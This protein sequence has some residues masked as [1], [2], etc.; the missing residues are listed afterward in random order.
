MR[1]PASKTATTFQKPD[2]HQKQNRASGGVDDC[3]DNSRTEMDTDLRQQPVAGE[4]ADN[5]DCD[6]A[7]KASEGTARDEERTAAAVLNETGDRTP[8]L[9]AALI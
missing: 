9:V 7:Y 5:T 4:R 2:D 8:A 6:I 3:R 1:A